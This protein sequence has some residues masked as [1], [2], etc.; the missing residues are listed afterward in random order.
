MIEP[1]ALLKADLSL[2]FLSPL[3]ITG[4][5]KRQLQRLLAI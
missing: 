5:H 4:R 2:Q 1:V 3:E